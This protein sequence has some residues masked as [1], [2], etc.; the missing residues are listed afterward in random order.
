MNSFER[1]LRELSIFI[2]RSLD[3]LENP[4]IRFLI[5]LILIIYTTAL[6][7]MLNKE[8]NKVFDHVV[9]KIIMLIIIV[10][11]GSKDPLI[12]LLFAIAFIMSLLHTTYYGTFGNVEVKDYESPVKAEKDTNEQIRD[13]KG[14]NQDDKQCSNQCMQTGNMDNGNKQCTPIAAFNNELNA[15]GMNCPMGEG[16]NLFGSPF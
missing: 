5:I 9:V 16:V 10:Y 4:T 3:F 1:L 13:D 12:A 7:P 11:L 15:Q 14:Y 8:L 2:D 6:V